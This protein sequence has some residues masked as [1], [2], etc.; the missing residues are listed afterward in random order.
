MS[1]AGCVGAAIGACCGAALGTQVTWIPHHV[2]GWDVAWIIGIPK[3]ALFGA[4]PGFVLGWA[5]G[6]S[7]PPKTATTREGCQA[8]A[9]R[10]EQDRGTS[11]TPPE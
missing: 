2:G 8:E 1:R 4:I 6:P 9:Q 7:R 11:V 5:F 10:R 3:A